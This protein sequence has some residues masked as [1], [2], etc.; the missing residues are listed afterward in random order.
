MN[1]HEYQAKQLFRASGIAIPDG[2]R[3]QGR[4]AILLFVPWK[5]SARLKYP[6]V[7][8]DSVPIR[9]LP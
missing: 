6:D 5:P 2:R 4:P 3:P 1:L 8:N 9:K 7:D